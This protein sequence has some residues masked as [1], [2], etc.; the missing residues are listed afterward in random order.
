[1]GRQAWVSGER[2]C[3][4]QDDRMTLLF[5]YYDDDDDDVVVFCGLQH[6]NNNN[7]KENN[8]E[9][10]KRIIGGAYL[11]RYTSTLY[12]SVHASDD[13][14]IERLFTLSTIDFFSWKDLRRF[15]LLL[16]AFWCGRWRNWLLD[17]PTSVIGGWWMFTWSPVV[18]VIGLVNADL[19]GLLSVYNRVGGECGDYLCFCCWCSSAIIIN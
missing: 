2:L 7:N 19:V 15:C 13:A 12:G 16:K 11:Y 14:S 10:N 6:T 5:F 18:C 8:N 3:A 9:M 17:I 1:M 4:T